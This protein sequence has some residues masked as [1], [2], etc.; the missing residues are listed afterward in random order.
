M[1]AAVLEAVGQPLQVQEIEIA[2][3][4]PGEARVRVV[5]CGLCHSDYSCV[6]GILRTPFPAVL[7]HEMGGVVE[8]VGPGVE[9]LAVGDHVV[10]VL[11][12]SCGDCEFCH[13]N[14]PFLCAGSV[15]MMVGSAML[16]GTTRLRRGSETVYQVCGIGGF[17]EQ[18][19]VPAG[20]LVKVDPGVPLEVICVLGCGV[21]T[22]VGAAINTAQVKPDTS[23]AVLGCGGVGLAVI[24]GARIA[25]ARQ[26]IAIDP[27]AGRR[28]I[29]RSIGATHELDPAAGDVVKAV[30]KMAPGGVHYAFEA[31]G[32]ADTVTQAFNMTRPSGA[33][34][35]VGA[36]KPSEEINI[37]AGGFLQNKALLGT[38]L[39]S[40]TPRRDL[41]QLVEW[42]KSGQLRLDEMVTHRIP[43]AN[44]ND[45]FELMRT[46]GGARAVVT[47]NR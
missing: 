24:Q 28:E 7:G 30:R 33:A 36:A 12:P 26:I 34:I 15:T 11:T 44:V 4:G 23:V 5:A 45:A 14:K 32:R 18:A 37:R 17:A 47:M 46:G 10:A 25:G 43:L 19:V 40:S 39:G 2:A 8:E 3:P 42:Y 13:E 41:P 20:A 16:D 35:V 22:G 27:V 9:H 38:L 31:I 29:A 1:R 21:L 6:H